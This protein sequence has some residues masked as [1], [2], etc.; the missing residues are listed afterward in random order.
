MQSPHVQ[1]EETFASDEQER[2]VAEIIHRLYK[3]DILRADH[4]HHCHCH[5]P[6]KKD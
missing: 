5:S 3:P 6:T 2:P 1:I 4:Y